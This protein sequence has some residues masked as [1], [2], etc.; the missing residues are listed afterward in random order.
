MQV[1]GGE[2]G[3][4]TGRIGDGVCFH[5]FMGGD[6]N[7][8]SPVPWFPAT[9]LNT[10][11]VL[12]L[13][14]VSVDLLL[15]RGGVLLLRVLVASRNGDDSI[16]GTDD[17]AGR[18]LMVATFV[19]VVVNVDVVDE[20]D[21]CLSACPPVCDGTRQDRFCS[22]APTTTTTTATTTTKKRSFSLRFVRI[23]NEQIT[24]K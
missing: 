24:A 14:G 11:D 16:N 21:E 15:R 10:N 3:L 5:R 19:P 18:N 17:A 20:G 22:F 9:G 13:F 7:G 12:A 6:R 8:D 23:C 2:T 1:T 4:D